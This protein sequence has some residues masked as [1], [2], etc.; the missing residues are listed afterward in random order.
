VHSAAGLAAAFETMASLKVLALLEAT[1]LTGVARNALEYARAAPLCTAG[2][3]VAVGLA[4]IRRCARHVPRLLGDAVLAV[5]LGAAARLRALT[6]HTPEQ[7]A[8]TL[9]LL[10]AALA[11]MH[12]DRSLSPASSAWTSSLTPGRHP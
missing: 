3:D 12:P 1:R 7:R 11:G 2:A 8:T 10:Y 4:L 9:S 6:R 5:E